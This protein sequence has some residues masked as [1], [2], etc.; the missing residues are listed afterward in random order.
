MHRDHE[1]DSGVMDA[2]ELARLMVEVEQ[3]EGG[4]L[5]SLRRRVERLWLEFGHA[6]SAIISEERT[7][8]AIKTSKAARRYR[9]AQASVDQ[10]RTGLRRVEGEVLVWRQAVEDATRQVEAA[11]CGLLR[12]YAAELRKR[13]ARRREEA[14]VAGDATEDV[15]VRHVG[16]GG[17][18]QVIV[19]RRPVRQRLELEAA[20]ITAYADQYHAQ[21]DGYERAVRELAELE[22]AE[23]PVPG[24]DLSLRMPHPEVAQRATARA[25]WLRTVERRRAGVEALRQSLAA[26]VN[27]ILEE[28]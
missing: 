21:A 15:P 12:E 23:P 9:D 18:D 26:T 25:D 5:D 17:L 28:E 27:Q 20:T 22:A 14:E 8:M 3:A 16:M 4:D 24:S 13:A 10:A 19:E 2:T 1:Y 6:S 7:S 11:Q